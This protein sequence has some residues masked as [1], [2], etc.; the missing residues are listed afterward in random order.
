MF[1]LTTLLTPT[2]P[3][4]DVKVPDGLYWYMGIIVAVCL[5]VFFLLPV[6]L[7]KNTRRPKPKQDAPD[8]HDP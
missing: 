3:I 2:V 5:V 8:A 7:S 4:K 1:P 6:L